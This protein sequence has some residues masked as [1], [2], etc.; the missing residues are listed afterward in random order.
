MIV[1]ETD[2]N[3][4]ILY[5]NTDFCEIAGFNKDELIGRP[6]NI[7]RHND[8]P[9][10]AF[11]DLWS[12]ISAGKTW[13]GIVKNL[14]KNGNFYWVSATAYQVTKQNGEKRYISVRSK[15]SFEQIQDASNLYKT[16]V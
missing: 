1:S 5:A 8:M 9:R 13:H 3:G 10:E 4:N 7:V 14:T 12:T 2:I 15:P 6:H 11:K 16:M